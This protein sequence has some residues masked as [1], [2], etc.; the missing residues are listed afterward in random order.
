[1]EQ[2]GKMEMEDGM[3]ERRKEEFLKYGDK[4]EKQEALRT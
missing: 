1:M 2:K 3:Q 4:K